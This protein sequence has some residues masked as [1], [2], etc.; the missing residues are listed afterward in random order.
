MTYLVRL[1]Y[2]VMCRVQG[3][4]KY[5]KRRITHQRFLD[6]GSM[7]EEDKDSRTQQLQTVSTAGPSSNRKNKGQE[8]EEYQTELSAGQRPK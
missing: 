4:D 1:S 7:H 2:R 6:G 3:G 8:Q 5:S